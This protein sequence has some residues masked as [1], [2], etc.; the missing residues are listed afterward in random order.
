MEFT[1]G[2]VT[3]GKQKERILKII[4]SIEE[5]NIEKY[6]IIIIG[7][8]KFFHK[9]CKMILFNPQSLTKKKNMICKNAKY[10]NLV[11]MH[12]YIILEKG[13][14]NGF[15]NFGNDWDICMNKIKTIDNERTIDWIGLPSCK[16]Y[17]NVNLPY[18]Y[19]TDTKNMYVSGSYFV[20]KKKIFRQHPLNENFKMFEA[21]DIE[22]SKRLLGGL[23]DS[24]WLLDLCKLDKTK[25]TK[26]P[27]IYKMNTE[28][29]VKFIKKKQFWKGF[30]QKYDMHSGDNSRPR[31]YKKEDYEYLLKREEMG[32]NYFILRKELGIDP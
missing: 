17:G 8:L 6:E 21:E 18:N 16:K 23:Y 32:N 11:I 1:F 22:W 24:K 3:S 4:K 28:S 30:F 5:E 25:E 27:C 20:V 13:W 26:N 2:I 10:E 15:T 19:V 29:S 7:D 12:D 14:Y 9:N 31:N